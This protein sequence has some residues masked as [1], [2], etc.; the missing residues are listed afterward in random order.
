MFLEK[1]GSSSSHSSKMLNWGAG[2]GQLQ[3]SLLSSPL[4]HHMGIR[5]QTDQTGQHSQRL[6]WDAHCLTAVRVLWWERT[7]AILSVC[8]HCQKASIIPRWVSLKMHCT[9]PTFNI[10]QVQ[11]TIRNEIDLPDNSRREQRGPQIFLASDQIVFI[12]VRNEH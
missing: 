11:S 10:L 12:P 1:T 2:K 6:T 8:L 9:L 5:R 7:D 3:R 4:L